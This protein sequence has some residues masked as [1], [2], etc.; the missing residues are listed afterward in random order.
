MPAMHTMRSRFNR[1]DYDRLPEG[2]PA[3]LIQGWLIKSPAPRYGHNLIALRIYEALRR[4]VP[5]GLV[6]MAPSDVGIDEWNVYQPDVAV[7][8]SVPSP[9]QSDVGVP[10]AVFEVLSPST[11][12][13]DRGVKLRAYLSAGVA[14]VWIVDPDG[15]R[16]ERHS[17]AQE[18]AS[19]AHGAE[20]LASQ[21]IAGLQLVPQT[22]FAP[23]S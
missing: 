4:V 22:L 11:A 1:A 2:Y 18:A 6:V 9:A 20:A 8:G 14:E 23:P 15:A 13:R 21:A 7:L 16:I 10:R 17:S 19:V 3:Q 12:R 5:Q